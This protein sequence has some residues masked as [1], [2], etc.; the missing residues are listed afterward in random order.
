MGW[1]I[2]WTSLEP[3]PREAFDEWEW[4]THAGEWFDAEPEGVPRVAVGV[5]QRVNRLKAIGNGQ[6]PSCAALAWKTLNGAFPDP[7]EKAHGG[8]K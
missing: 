8:P 7:Q 4:R 2:S 3:L 5:P 1:P 6:V